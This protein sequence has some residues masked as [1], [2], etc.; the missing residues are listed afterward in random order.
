[1]G[2]KDE[3]TDRAWAG[4]TVFNGLGSYPQVSP[5]VPTPEER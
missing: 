3:T 2:L 4:R 5:K 1:M